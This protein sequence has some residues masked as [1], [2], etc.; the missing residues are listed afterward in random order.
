MTVRLTKL[1]DM[2]IIKGSF[3]SC[4]E[5]VNEKGGI[6]EHITKVVGIKKFYLNEIIS[7]SFN[8]FNNKDKIVETLVINKEDNIMC[9]A[10]EF[11]EFENMLEKYWLSENEKEMCECQKL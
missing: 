4:I 2:V 11:L 10:N 5:I 8:V 7:A 3:V 1:E 9:S 6:K